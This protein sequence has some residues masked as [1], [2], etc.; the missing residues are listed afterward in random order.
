MK[1]KKIIV[2]AFTDNDIIAKN[3]ISPTAKNLPSWY[4]KLKPSLNINDNGHNVSIPTFKRCDGMADLIGNSFT[5]PMWADI[6]IVVD[7]HGAYQWKYPSQPFNFGVEQHAEFQMDSA[8]SPFVHMKI[9]SPWFLKEKT[10]VNFYQTQAFYSTN[11]LTGDVVM[12]PGVLNYKFQNSTHINMFLQ[13]DRHYLFEAGQG[14]TYLIPITENEVEIKTHVISEQEYKKMAVAQY[15]FKFMG[16]YKH[17]KS[18][19]C[20]INGGS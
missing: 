4:K 5:L 8:F 13:R 14:M 16:S 6:S 15:G 19:G 18:K 9:V 10:G 2:D 11:H 3:P 20:P 1:K 12:P 7:E 17:I